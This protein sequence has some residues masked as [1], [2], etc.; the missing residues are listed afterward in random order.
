MNSKNSSL[1]CEWD[2]NYVPCSKNIWKLFEAHNKKK[3]CITHFHIV[4]YVLY[5]SGHTNNMK[6]SHSVKTKSVKSPSKPPPEVEEVEKIKIGKFAAD[7]L[8]PLPLEGTPQ[9]EK[10]TKKWTPV[11]T[12]DV[13]A[14]T[15]PN[16]PPIRDTEVL[17]NPKLSSSQPIPK[18]KTDPI[19]STV[20]LASSSGTSSGG[21]T[22]GSSPGIGRRECTAKSCFNVEVKHVYQGYFCTEHE[23][24]IKGYRSIIDV[25]KK[26]L[27][28]L[29]AREA[30]QNLRKIPHPLY[31]KDIDSLKIKLRKAEADFINNMFSTNKMQTNETYL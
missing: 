10:S 6:D 24:I 11:Q 7:L 31:Q 30:E 21:S 13:V 4:E 3:Y 12:K 8:P 22:P 25:N 23:N 26:D 14:K 1:E 27:K 9:K 17:V 29:H 19:V 20:A 2:Y 16:F 15:D 28:E 18:T 5:T